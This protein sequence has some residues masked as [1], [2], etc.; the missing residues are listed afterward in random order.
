MMDKI[1]LTDLQPNIFRLGFLIVGKRPSMKECASQITTVNFGETFAMKN[2]NDDEGIALL[3]A[4]ALMITLTMGL[5]AL[6]QL[7]L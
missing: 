1:G 2:N 4:I 6:V 5:N 7:I 3:F